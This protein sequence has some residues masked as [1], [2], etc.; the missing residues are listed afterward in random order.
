[1]A[2]EAA[3]KP[4]DFEQRRGVFR[5]KEDEN[6]AQGL[7]S[8]YWGEKK[9]W[10]KTQRHRTKADIVVAK[11][12]H[13]TEAE[14][15]EE[16]RRQQEELER[17]SEEAARKLIEQEEEEHARRLAESEAVARQLQQEENAR[18]TVL[19]KQH[20]G[21]DLTA[22]EVQRHLDTE[23]SQLQEEL[24]LQDEALVERLNAIEQQ[25]YSTAMKSVSSVEDTE[26]EGFGFDDE[27]E[28]V[29]LQAAAAATPA[30]AAATPS[31]DDAEFLAEQQHLVKRFQQLQTD[32]QLARRLSASS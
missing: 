12:V 15:A 10:N 31:N 6:I 19:V 20:H 22:A 13:M 2:E 28:D 29:P 7:S 4:E 25:Q 30:A 17:Q 32:A 18:L 3:V 21:D 26:L 24:R 27:V 1:M 8:E 23:R 5:L 9:K 11:R 16:Y 14:L